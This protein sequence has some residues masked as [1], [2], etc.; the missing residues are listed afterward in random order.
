MMKL[1]VLD[2]NSLVNR[3]FY[4]I[5][6][7]TTHDGRYTNAIFGFLNILTKLREQE[8]PD[9]VA[10]A[11]DLKAPTFRHKMYDGY[12]AQ[13]KGMPEELA[14]QMPVLKELLGYLGYT[15]I[16]AEGWE[17]D[18]ILGTLAAACAA[19]GDECVLA[20]GDRD[21]LQLIDAHTRVLL[22]TT[23]ETVDMT[24]EAVQEKYG[25]APRQLIDVKALMGDT[26]DNIPGV[27]GIGEKTALALIAKFGSLD[28]VYENIADPAI[29]PGV[30]TKLEAG[31]ESAYM[32][33]TLA[34]IVCDAPVPLKA[35]DY[36][37][38]AGDRVAA[39]DLLTALEMYSQIEKLGLAVEQTGMEALLEN[40][41]SALPFVAA[42]PLNAE[43]L[44]TV[45]L[46]AAGTVDAKPW[47]LL[48][49]AELVWTVQDDTV[50]CC[51]ESEPALAALLAD[52]TVEKYCFD[53]KYFAHIA[54]NAGLTAQNITLDGQLAAYLIDPSATDY[55]VEHL[56]GRYRMQPAWYTAA[57]DGTDPG[58]APALAQDTLLALKNDCAEKDMLEL[59]D[60]VEL[61][62]AGVLAGME[63]DGFAVDK[64]GLLAFGA[65]I[66]AQLK[67][68]LD[69]IY[70]IVGHE[71]NLNSPKQLGEVLFEEL[72][73]PTRKK[74]KSGYSTNAETL[75]SLRKY[76]PVIEEILQYRVYQKLDSTYVEG[77][78][79]KIG[80]DG[81]IRSTFNQTETR[82]GRISSGEP[83]LQN[84]PVRTPLGSQM[85][86]FFVAAPGKVLVDADYSQIELRLLAHISGDEAMREAFLTGADIHR[87]TAARVYNMPEEMI[88][89]ALRSSAKA[90]NFG[91]VY[92]IGAFSLSKDIGVSVK[93]AEAFINNY[94]ASFPK[95]KQYM[96]DTVEKGREQG[97]VT[98]L[99]KRRRNLPELANSNFN[100]RELGKRMAMNTPIQ[101]TAADIIKIAM[102]K[103]A[104]RLAAE[105]PS[106]RLILQVHDELIVEC[107]AEE[108]TQVER[109][110]CEEMESAATLSV[111][112]AADVHSGT[113]WYA[114]KGE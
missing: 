92:G 19:A 52:P 76:H 72:G 23:K 45:V 95:V 62:L 82:T 74:T 71:F 78:L 33:R 41:Q 106:A 6:L 91:I 104:Q 77:L 2:G 86:R 14:Q 7:L 37:I 65:E 26:S 17:A 73:L 56:A 50:L 29:K 89:P 54:L 42:V 63:H 111:P 70:T 109:I 108:Q 34:E 58:A 16:S 3:A 102:V 4:G 8:A 28:G 60:T 68:H 64:E 107:P 40:A 93:E 101:G 94:F 113:T 38:G 51:A 46:A 114:A 61:P 25:V 32:S 5:K 15:C 81:R 20:T 66:K 98:T 12:K 90:V 83:N 97:Y 10:I 39:A 36:V 105:K 84:I 88:T 79:K 9:A 103:V 11:F 31:R 21:S 80:P 96:D 100:V 53:A 24:V 47:C 85:R 99:Y 48:K 35:A 110:V 112:L 44:E 13:R 18:D 55:A 59:H 49:A 69:N 75:E 22:A 30:R 67:T 43:T 57:A 87:S 1:M 27:A